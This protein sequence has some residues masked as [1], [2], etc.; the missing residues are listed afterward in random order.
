MVAGGRF[1]ANL[2]ALRFVVSRGVDHL[3]IK[4]PDMLMDAGNTQ[5][6]QM[7]C[8]DAAVASARRGF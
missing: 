2:A 1:R 7:W 4:R 5:N 6:K 3:Y 8:E